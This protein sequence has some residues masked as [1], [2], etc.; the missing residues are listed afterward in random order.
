MVVALPLFA[1]DW[2]VS[3]TPE[4]KKLAHYRDLRTKDDLERELYK[5]IRSRD[6]VGV[7]V[8]LKTF[9]KKLG[10]DPN[11]T[12]PTKLFGETV[13]VDPAQVALRS[14][15]FPWLHLAA[16]SSSAEALKNFLD[17]GADP[18]IKD[19]RGN[20]ALHVAT[21]TLS[22]NAV[23]VLLKNKALDINAANKTGETALEITL[24]SRNPL[25]LADFAKAGAKLPQTVAGK[26]LA[27][28]LLSSDN[29]VA[30]EAF[31]RSKSD[32]ERLFPRALINAASHNA[33]R[34]SKLLIHKYK[35]SLWDKDQKSQMTAF[36]VALANT[37]YDLY[38]LFLDA[39]PKIAKHK[40]KLGL[41]IAIAFSIGELA[42]ADKLFR[43][44]TP[45]VIEKSDE[46][47][48]GEK[49]IVIADSEAQSFIADNE[50]ALKKNELTADEKKKIKNQIDVAKKLL[51]RI[52]TSRD[53]KLVA[54]IPKI[55]DAW[56]DKPIQIAKLRAL[57]KSSGKKFSDLTDYIQLNEQAYYPSYRQATDFDSSPIVDFLMQELGSFRAFDEFVTKASGTSGIVFLACRAVRMNDKTAA[58]LLIKYLN[59]NERVF[60]ETFV[61]PEEFSAKSA[62]AFGSF[63]VARL[64]V[65][66]RM[67]LQNDLSS[68]ERKMEKDKVLS[69][70]CDE[71]KA[72]RDY[73]SKVFFEKSLSKKS[74]F[75]K[76]FATN[77]IEALV[78]PQTTA[79]NGYFSTLDIAVL[80][81]NATLTQRLL[82]AGQKPTDLYLKKLNRSGSYVDVSALSVACSLKFSNFSTICEKEQGRFKSIDPAEARTFLNWA[83]S[84]VSR[85]ADLE[86]NSPYAE[87]ML[88]RFASLAAGDLDTNG[89]RERMRDML[90]MFT[91]LKTFEQI[92][93]WGLVK[94]FIL[95]QPDVVAAILKLQGNVEDPAHVLAVIKKLKS[96]GVQFD[97]LDSR[98]V[99]IFFPLLYQP[100]P[101]F[102]AS[103]EMLRGM[104]VDIHK[105]SQPDNNTLLFDAS[106]ELQVRHVSEMPEKIEWLVKNGL[107]PNA[108]DDSGGTFWDNALRTDGTEESLAVARQVTDS[109]KKLGYSP[110][111]KR[112]GQSH[113]IEIPE[114]VNLNFLE[115]LRY[116]AQELPSSEESCRLKQTAAQIEIQQHISKVLAWQERLAGLSDQLKNLALVRRSE[117]ENFEKIQELLFKALFQMDY[118]ENE[119]TSG[120][121]DLCCQVTSASC[122]HALTAAEVEKKTLVSTI[123][124]PLC[125]MKKNHDARHLLGAASGGYE[126]IFSIRF[127][128][129]SGEVGFEDLARIIST[130]GKALEVDRVSMIVSVDGFTSAGDK[131]ESG[132]HKSTN[133]LTI[134]L[135]GPDASSSTVS[136]KTLK[137][138]SL[139][140]RENY[141]R[142]YYPTCTQYLDQWS[143]EQNQAQGR[144]NKTSPSTERTKTPPPDTAQEAH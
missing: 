135:Y 10:F 32:V 45:L 37:H 90:F 33:Q 75:W 110:L 98:G 143:K 34:I 132:V 108:V 77:D 64:L 67:G 109:L 17:F 44:G 1:D 35:Y 40:G 50:E 82:L 142:A 21:A 70:I 16:R 3:R 96:W 41:P 137:A 74:E 80:M 83:L 131:D 111:D 119:F 89:R 78:K 57:L 127:G 68:C 24:A 31:C 138:F 123:R 115:G 69:K 133:Y 87:F 128:A 93:K 105:R 63:D 13:S 55:R 8:L 140:S 124:E 20:T 38:K 139:D 121:A 76:A 54:L 27:E 28:A 107:S 26:P 19:E 81:N 52:R 39:D 7:K 88:R 59:P 36:E 129:L 30:I 48:S 91:S 56:Y 22:K 12:V 118:N 120:Q 43:L 97:A 84:E 113:Q 6:A 79:E 116:S 95:D 134:G 2:Q 144:S 86:L 15:T 99:P 126:E 130:D 102:K 103:M 58:K 18:N 141:M 42:L 4:A 66:S 94:S 136:A 85:G 62:F 61:Q 73:R 60:C 23:Q 92:E 101:V 9:G 5:A 100:Y 104:G 72:Y 65:P 125:A 25:L 71:V 106:V 46:E 114:R 51:V 14:P 53:S 49:A 47:F 112:E 122:Y 117:S 11:V 29:Y